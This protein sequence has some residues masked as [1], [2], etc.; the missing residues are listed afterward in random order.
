MKTALAALLN[1][2]FA[3]DFEWRYKGEVVSP[4]VLKTGIGQIDSL[5]G[6]LPRGAI[7]EIHGPHSSGRTTLLSAILADATQKDEVCAIVDAC[8]AFDPVSADASGVLLDRILWVRCSGNAELAMRVMDLILQSGGFGIVVMDLGDTPPKT[9]RRISLAS[10]YRYRRTVEQ[11]RTVMIVLG[12]EPYA[13]QCASLALEASRESQDWIGTAGCSLL[14]DQMRVRVDK[15]KP[16]GSV[17]R[18][19]IPFRAVG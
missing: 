9:A 17:T 6:G 19:S 16:V 7:T 13:R 4:D 1:G 12:L 15:R 10:W 2:R 8:D 18:A 5:T 3:A 14:L 11:T